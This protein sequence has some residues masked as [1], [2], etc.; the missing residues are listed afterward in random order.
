MK[1]S[2]WEATD[3]SDGNV[4]DLDARLSALTNTFYRIQPC[5]FA[6]FNAAVYGDSYFIDKFMKTNDKR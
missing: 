4:N 2:V 3:C 1:H 5:I 6:L